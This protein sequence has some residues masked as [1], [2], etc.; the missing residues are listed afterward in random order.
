M[1]A[2]WGPTRTKS[3]ECQFLYVG[4]HCH[5]DCFH[6]KIFS[7]SIFPNARHLWI[8]FLFKNI[9]TFSRSAI[10]EHCDVFIF[11][12]CWWYLLRQRFNCKTTIISL[13]TID[14]I[15]SSFCWGFSYEIWNKNRRVRFICV[16]NII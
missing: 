15:F 13:I 11:S 9:E 7:L 14:V 10:F 1:Y 2:C 3:L 5:F 8:S 12:F 4:C 16:P 6:R